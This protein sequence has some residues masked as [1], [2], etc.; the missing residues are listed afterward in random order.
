MGIL[1]TFFHLRASFIC[2]RTSHLFR[3]LFC[4]DSSRVF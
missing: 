3:W 4:A 1:M 2:T